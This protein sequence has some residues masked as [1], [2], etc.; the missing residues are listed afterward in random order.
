MAKPAYPNPNSNPLP[1][2]AFILALPTT[3]LFPGQSLTL[4]LPD[5]RYRQA[6]LPL[7]E[8]DAPL[9]VCLAKTFNEATLLG[10]P[11]EVGCLLAV[12]GWIPHP[13]GGLTLWGHGLNRLCML[14]NTLSSAQNNPASS[15]LIKHPVIAWQEEPVPTELETAQHQSLLTLF[16][17]VYRLYQQ[18]QKPG[19]AS[20]NRPLPKISQAPQ[21]P[22]ALGYWIS[23]QLEGSLVLRQQLLEERQSLKRLH[24]LHQLLEEA[25]NCLAAQSQIEQAFKAS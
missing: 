6:L 23:S 7:L 22:D 13:M 16:S 21:A 3:V 8:T 1:G 10:D 12:E 14:E 25:A 9:M 2:H 19:S 11:F 18:L 15:V 17:E 24:R 5:F 20:P 4:S